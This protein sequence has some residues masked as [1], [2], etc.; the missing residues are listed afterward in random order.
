[1][2]RT[3]TTNRNTQAANREPAS[4]APAA[5][6]RTAA[7][8]AAEQERDEVDE[9]VRQ[10]RAPRRRTREAA[11]PPQEVAPPPPPAETLPTRTEQRNLAPAGNGHRN[12]FEAYG[13]QMAMS[14]IVGT[15]IKFN[16]GDW[17][18]GDDEDLEEN[19][20]LVCNMNQLFVGWIKWQDQRP[21]EHIMGLVV[22]NYQAPTRNSLGDQNQ[23]DWEVDDQGRARDPWQFSN[24]IVMKEPGMPATEDNLY[25]F[26]T[27]SKGGL[28]ALGNL[29]KVYGKEMR[30]REGEYPIVRLGSDS[31][32]HRE[33]GRTKIPLLTVVGWEPEAQFEAP[34][35][36]EPE[37]AQSPARGGGGRRR[38][39]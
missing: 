33:Y 4:A 36:R 9:E 28:G 18:T 34:A 13:A 29:C 17:V 10:A 16:K 30:T 39:A 2:V 8:T 25:T 23:D 22:D 37:P 15:L 12:A 21:T 6:T 35:S 38:S 3:R 27:S 32:I 20:E 7:P 31:Y 14:T 11:A 26:A 19:L 5:P 24:Y 1:M